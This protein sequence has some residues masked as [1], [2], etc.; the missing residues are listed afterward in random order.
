MTEEVVERMPVCVGVD[1]H[2][3]SHTL[4]WVDPVG[5]V[6]G[7][8]VTQGPATFAEAVA[9]VQQA[10]VAR[11]VAMRWGLESTGSYGHAFAVF[12]VAQGMEVYEV[13]PRLAHR[14]RRLARR[15]G[16]SDQLDAHAVA[17]VVLRE[18]DRLSR[19]YGEPASE[20]LRLYYDLRDRLVRERT[21]EI[22]RLRHALLR[23]GLPTVPPDLTTARSQA[24]LRAALAHHVTAGPIARAVRLEVDLGLAR[25]AQLTT[26]IHTIEGRLRPLA[27]AWPSLLALRGVSTCVAAGLVGHA[28]DLRNLRSAAAFAMRSGTA[29]VPHASGKTWHVRVNHGGNRQLNRL[30]YI[31]AMVQRC[32]PGHPGQLYYAR[33]LAEGKTPRAAMRCLKRRLA[34][35]IYHALQTDAASSAQELAA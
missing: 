24:T 9:Q 14:Q 18:G 17:L 13:P 20:E 35:V 10:A 2:A 31:V 1:C 25:L 15:A 33:K 12:L 23:L 8:Y 6:L 7:E 27:K 4:V 26:D 16:K 5:R 3:D 29:P 34:N 21:Q 30:L 22:N 11:G 19:F 28:G 32:T